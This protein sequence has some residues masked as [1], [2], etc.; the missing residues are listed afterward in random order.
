MKTCWWNW[1]KFSRGLMFRLTARSVSQRNPN[2]APTGG[3]IRKC[4]TTTNA[5]SWRKHSPKKL[6]CTVIDLSRNSKHF[7]AGSIQA[8]LRSEERRVGKE[9]RSRVVR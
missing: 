9:D 7:Y 6:N 1:V 3:H 2:I 4:S 5:E 8:C